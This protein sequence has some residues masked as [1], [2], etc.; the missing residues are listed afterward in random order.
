MKAFE[1]GLLIF[2]FGVFLAACAGGLDV[3]FKDGTWS[4]CTYSDSK[5]RVITPPPIQLGGA[6]MEWTEPDGTSVK[7]VPIP[8]EPMPEPEVK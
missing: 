7:C 3:N 1:K 6:P 2:I 4:S 8:K 5:G